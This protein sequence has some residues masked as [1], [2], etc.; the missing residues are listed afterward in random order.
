[1]DRSIYLYRAV[2]Y[3]RGA[4]DLFP[5]RG[6]II[7][8]LRPA[9]GGN[10]V[11]FDTPPYTPAWRLCIPSRLSSLGLSKSPRDVASPETVS[12][13]DNDAETVLL[14]TRETVPRRRPPHSV[15]RERERRSYH[16]ISKFQNSVLS[17]N[18]SA[19]HTL[20]VRARV[21]SIR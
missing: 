8:G 19:G 14:V 13:P 16:Y 17:V 5:F 18:Q 2:L 6:Y 21:V 1:M 15:T 3:G 10:A 20:S 9:V 7:V 12:Y 11:H 4:R